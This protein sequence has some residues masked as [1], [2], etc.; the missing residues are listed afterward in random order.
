MIRPADG[1]VTVAGRTCRLLL[2]NVSSRMTA[3]PR[4]DMTFVVRCGRGY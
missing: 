4:G 2:V 3:S 1:D